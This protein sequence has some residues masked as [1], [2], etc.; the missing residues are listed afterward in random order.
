MRYLVILLL[1]I[2][3][4]FS[5]QVNK[6]DRSADIGLVVGTAYYIGDIN[7]TKHFGT[8]LKLSGGITYRNNVS[9]R[10]SIKTSLLYGQVEAWDADNENAWIQN[11]NLHFKNQFMEGSIQAELNYFD[12]QIGQSSS[13]I[14]P[15]LFAGL[16]YYQM[17]PQAYFNGT[18]YELQ[19]LGTE[20]QGTT[21]GGKKYNVNGIAMPFGAGLKFNVYAIFG[22]SIEWGT[23]RT[24]TDYFDDVSTVYAEPNMLENENGDLAALLADQSIQKE[25]PLGDNTGMQRGDPG[26]KDW[27]FFSTVSLN[28]RIDK[29]PTSC[30]GSVG[31]RINL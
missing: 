16:A 3:N 31:K 11:R 26:R 18:W 23:R 14:S 27:Y 7:P 20:G 6:Y 19:P 12:Y 8:R 5:A 13:W 4:V 25:G 21:Q 28:I 2:P 17:K 29:P 24:W 10:W 9:K 15:Y 1:F 30:W 22:I